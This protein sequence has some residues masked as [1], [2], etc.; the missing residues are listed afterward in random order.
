MTGTDKV[1]NNSVVCL[2]RC[3]P[4]DLAAVAVLGLTGDPDPLVAGLLAEAA[5]PPGLGER[6]TA[7]ALG[8]RS[9]PAAPP[10]CGQR[11]DDDDLVASH[12]ICGAPDQPAI[13]QSA[14]QP[15]AHV[16]SSTCSGPLPCQ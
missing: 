5:D 10:G 8:L 1:V 3:T 15:A 11:P 6:L 7:R 4:G 2:P 9:T 12:L 16:G 14:G 13:G